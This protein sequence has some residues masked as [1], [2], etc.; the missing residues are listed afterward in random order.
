MP[1]NIDF[2]AMANTITAVATLVATVTFAAAFTL[3]GGLRNNAPDE[4][5]PDFME[6]TSLKAFIMLDVVAFYCSATVVYLTV[7]AMFGDL[8]LSVNIAGLTYN[9]LMVAVYAMV[10]AFGTALYV[11]LSLKNLWMAIVVACIGCGVPLLV[12]LYLRYSIRGSFG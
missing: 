9:L 8:D 7:F 1:H 6:R 3:P 12:G 11:V 2:R 10:I 5:F 4:G